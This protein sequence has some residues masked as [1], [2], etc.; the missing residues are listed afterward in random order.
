MTLFRTRALRFLVLGMVAALLLT[1]LAC[2]GEIPVEMSK[3]IYDV[4]MQRELTKAKPPGLKTWADH[5]G[6]IKWYLAKD[7][8][9][10]S[11]E[12]LLYIDTKRRELGLPYYPAKEVICCA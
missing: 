3:A 7:G 8:S 1:P 5:W 10:R 2:A 11:R 6:S 4:T 9:S 12:M